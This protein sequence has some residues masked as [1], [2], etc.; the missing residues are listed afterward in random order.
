MI[1]KQVFEDRVLKKICASERDEVCG[2]L[3]FYL[4]TNLPDRPWSFE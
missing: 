4:T 1:N 2:Q 3:G